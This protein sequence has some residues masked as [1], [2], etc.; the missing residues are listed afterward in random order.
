MS[1]TSIQQEVKRIYE[2][3][4]NKKLKEYIKKLKANNKDANC[5]RNGY[6]DKLVHTIAGTI[7][8]SIPRLRYYSFEY[9]LFE[10]ELLNDSL[11]ILI[12]ELYG[13]GLSTRRI[14]NS[15]Y[16]A[17]GI[18][19]SK[20]KVSD[21]CKILKYN[22][23]SYF[24]RSLDTYNFQVIHVDAKYYKVK[25]VN[26]LRKSALI[27][28]I[29]ITDEGKRIHL[30]MDVYKSE[31]KQ[32]VDCFLEELKNRIGDTEACFVIDGNTNLSS[33]I[34]SKFPNANVQRCL[35]HVIRNT[36]SKLKTV[37]SIT[38]TS[39]IIN[40][41]TNILFN[42]HN[43]DIKSKIEI[44]LRKY[45]KYNSIFKNYLRCEHVWTFTKINT[46]VDCKT[47]NNIEGFHSQLESVTSQHNSFEDKASLYKALIR[48]I[49]RYNDLDAII[50]DNL[51]PVNR[52]IDIGLMVKDLKRED[53]IH[54][55]V[56]NNGRKR[57][58]QEITKATYD[59]IYSIVMME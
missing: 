45:V 27:N 44:F 15:L 16:E 59:E 10:A 54:I 46:I 47:N 50:P 25:S 5:E 4:L 20:S 40:E 6:Y 24:E 49:E 19:I 22:I 36:E 31:D 55:K 8:L 43:R 57:I 21:L 13:N 52:P 26:K 58:N 48:E 3:T 2:K 11:E 17:F 35:A 41:L 12:P 32:Y 14:S 7:K 56:I 51:N 33:S 9:E 23:D 39:K 18:N 28:A 30:H 53:L 37:V 42:T 1:I 29:G 38:E 34:T